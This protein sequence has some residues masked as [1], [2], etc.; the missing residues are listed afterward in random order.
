ML[1]LIFFFLPPEQTSSFWLEQ[2]FARKEHVTLK[3]RENILI[4]KWR[5]AVA[6]PHWSA[7]LKEAGLTGRY[8]R[9]ETSRRR[10]S[11][12]RCEPAVWA[13]RGAERAAEENKRT[14]HWAWGAGAWGAGAE[15][16][17]SN[18]DSVIFGTRTNP[19][20]S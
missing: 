8:A 10:G 2:T 1:S 13:G 9:C 6:A 11:F 17:T 20:T 18:W 16:M 15:F 3:A 12:G 7:C 19:V 5:R 4:Y 14:L